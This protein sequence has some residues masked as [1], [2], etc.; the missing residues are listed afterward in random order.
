MDA[1]DQNPP[2]SNRRRRIRAAP[3]HDQDAA[4]SD[5]NV[6]YG[7]KQ[8][9]YRRRSID[10]R[11]N[12]G[13]GAHRPVGLR[14][15]DVP[16]LPQ[17]H[18]RHDRRLPGRPARSCSTARTST[19]RASTWCS[20]APASAWCSRS[21]T[22]SRSRSTRTSPTARASMASPSQGRARR[23]RRASAA[24]RRPVGRGEGPAA[25][26][27]APACPAAS[28]SACASRAPSRSS[29]EVI[30]MDEPCSALDPIATAKIEELI[31]EL[32]QLHD[33]HRHA[34]D[35]A[36]GAR[37]AA[38]RVL[39]PRRAGRV[40]RDT[41]RSSPTRTTSGP[42]T[43][44][45]AASAEQRR[46]ERNMVR[47]STRAATVASTTNARRMARPDPEMGR[48]QARSTRSPS[49]SACQRDSALAQR[50]VSRATTSSTRRARDRATRAIR[51]IALRQPVADDL[52]RGH[53]RA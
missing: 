3:T 35:A 42:R 45:P 26:S 34:L 53:G 8:A 39:P 2:L 38:H 13:H 48:L 29:P 5:V 18:E 28:S 15:V 27:P 12:D 11:E 6:F 49:P 43:T 52:R 25:R 30:L 7:E 36:G 1:H 32:R 33:R 19:T 46:N 17:P 9:L 50:V 40:R 14:Q 10:I 22:R 4:A 47:T 24:A 44:S 23:D 20:C 51:L 21:R 31:D 16:A 41:A 37:L